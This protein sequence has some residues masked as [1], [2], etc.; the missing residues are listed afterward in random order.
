MQIQEKLPSEEIYQ[1]QLIN[2]RIQTEPEPSGGT[3]RF[4]IVEHPGGVAIVALRYDKKSEHNTEPQVLLVSQKRPA[5]GKNLW[6]IPAG[7]V[8]TSE[9]TAPE[10]AAARELQEE[11]GYVAENLQCLVHTYPSPGFSNETV[12]IYLAH[13]VNTASDTIPAGTPS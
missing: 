4:E 11:T 5:V 1:G 3:T 9:R 7:M 10:L 13:L 12:T 8:E 6:E 2:V